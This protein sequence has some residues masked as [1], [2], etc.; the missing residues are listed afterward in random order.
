MSP[1]EL[2]DRAQA[3]LDRRSRSYVE[4]AHHFAVAIV[5]LMGDYA[6][7]ADRLTVANT[8]CTE[9]ETD[10]RTLRTAI[11]KIADAEPDDRDGAVAEA[12][13]AVGG[14]P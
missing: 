14:M 2:Q 1:N 6:R 12:L 5:K 8:R 3:V 11:Q 4:D 10:R 7:L 13:V 9:L